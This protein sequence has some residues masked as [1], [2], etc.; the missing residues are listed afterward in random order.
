MRKLFANAQT[1]DTAC[2]EYVMSRRKKSPKQLEDDKKKYGATVVHIIKNMNCDEA[3]LCAHIPAIK[4]K[5]KKRRMEEE[6]VEL[7]ALRCQNTLI[8]QLLNKRQKRTRKDSGTSFY[9]SS[10][11]K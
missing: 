4:M 1:P 3:A 6:Q 9:S 7:N 2:T 10:S 5:I 8:K 11:S